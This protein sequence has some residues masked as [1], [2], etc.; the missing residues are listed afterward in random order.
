MII[1]RQSAQAPHVPSCPAHKEEEGVRVKTLLT[2]VAIFAAFYVL[3][4][5]ILPR[6]GIRG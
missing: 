3:N 6:L 2:L 4:R 5:F 1:I